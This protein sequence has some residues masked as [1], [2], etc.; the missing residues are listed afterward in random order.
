M[1]ILICYG[2]TDGQTRRIAEFTA[3]IVRQRGYDVVL[4]DAC[5]AGDLEPTQYKAAILAGSVHMGRYQAPLVHW[6]KQWHDALNAMPTIFV[7]VSLAAASRDPHDRSEIDECAQKM[8]HDTGW[9]PASTAHV[10]GAIRFTEYD[11]FK[12]WLMRMMARQ[13]GKP[14]DPSHDQEYT[15]W[16]VVTRLTEEFLATLGSG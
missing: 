2:T 12:R 13:M 15:D 14:A 10:A 3:G 11:F 9:T 1:R 5:T 6:I 16:A 4:Q 7:S 8:L